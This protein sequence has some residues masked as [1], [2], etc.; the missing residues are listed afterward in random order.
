MVIEILPGQFS[1]CKLS[2]IPS[3]PDGICFFARTDKEISLVCESSKIDFKTL[4][5]DDNWRCLRVAGELDFSLIGI[6]AGITDALAKAKISVFCVSTYDT[7]YVLIKSEN[8]KKAIETLSTAGYKIE[9]A[10]R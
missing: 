8:F 4:K 10:C 7:D 1:V 2:S 6:L 5:R 9:D 3:I